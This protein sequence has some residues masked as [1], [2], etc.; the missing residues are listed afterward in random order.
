MSTKLVLIPFHDNILLEGITAA[1]QTESGLIIPE[2]HRD[3]PPQGKVIDKGP[4][5]S[6]QIQIGDILFYPLHSE[7]SMEYKGKKFKMISESAVLGAIRS[8]DIEKQ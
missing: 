3:A 8:V 2:R 5:C 7:A 6:D 1:V 4:D